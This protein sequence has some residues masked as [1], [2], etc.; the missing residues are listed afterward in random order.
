MP[1]SFDRCVKAGGRV[2]TLSGPHKKMGL[3]EGEYVKVCF[4][5]KGKKVKMFRGHVAR[6][7]ESSRVAEVVESS[8]GKT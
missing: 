6:K 1:A 5:G 2:R 4:L 7:K 3:K 8:Y